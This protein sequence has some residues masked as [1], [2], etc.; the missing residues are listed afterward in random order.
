MLNKIDVIGCY[1]SATPDFKILKLEGKD[2]KTII[3]STVDGLYEEYDITLEDFVAKGIGLGVWDWK[4]DTLVENV[5][6]SC[7]SELFEG[8]DWDELY[9]E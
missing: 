2:N 8:I 3:Y 9:V 5:N 1:R 4:N 6:T 7:W